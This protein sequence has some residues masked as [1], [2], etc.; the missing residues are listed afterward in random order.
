M[1]GIFH[2]NVK[3][4]VSSTRN[5]DI[6]SGFRVEWG[7]PWQKNKYRCWQM[8]S[9]M[10]QRLKSSIKIQR[11]VPRV[12]SA[13]TKIEQ[14]QQQ[15]RS[16]GGKISFRGMKNVE[17]DIRVIDGV[18]VKITNIR[19]TNRKFH[20]VGTLIKRTNTNC[21]NNYAI[22]D[23]FCNSVEPLKCTQYCT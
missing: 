5:Y 9:S 22:I 2:G 11:K 10:A 6:A 13:Q 15:Y 4:R 17:S 23:F 12:Y 18:P 7:H 19:R 1:R 20:I 16:H 21:L 8:A 3:S 14:Q